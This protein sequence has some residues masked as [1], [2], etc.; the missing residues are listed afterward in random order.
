[1][2]AMKGLSESDNTFRTA[3]FVMFG[4][5]FLRVIFHC[6]FIAVL[7]NYRLKSH[8][9]NGKVD[10]S[11][12]HRQIVG[13]STA[14]LLW[15]WTDITG[16]G[17]FVIPISIA[18]DS[19]GNLYVVDDWG[20]SF[21]KYSNGSWSDVADWEAGYP[22]GVTVDGS[23][24]LYV[25]YITDADFPYG[26]VKRRVNDSWEDITGNIPFFEPAGIAVDQNGDAYV[27]SSPN[28][29]LKG[30]NG[31]WSSV[32][33][34]GYCPAAVA[35]DSSG[36]MYSIFYHAGS[37]CIGYTGVMKLSGGTWIELGEIPKTSVEKYYYNLHIDRYDNIYAVNSTNQIYKMLITPPEVR[38][39]NISPDSGEVAQGGSLQL[40]AIVDAV[41]FADESVTWSSSDGKITVD[42]T[43]KVTAAADAAP[44]D[45]TITATSV[46][47]GTKQG[48]ATIT[49]TG[50]Q[51]TTAPVISLT[52]A[53]DATQTGATLHFTSDEAGMYYY[54]VYK[55]SEPAPDAPA[56]EA[57]GTA[58]AKGTGAANAGANTISVTSGLTAA[59]AYKAYLIVKD[60]AGNV[61]D[62]AEIS[63]TTENPPNSEISPT[64][65]TF[66]KYSESA[67]YKDIPVTL[68]LKGNQLGSIA[69]GSTT[70]EVGMD[71]TVSGKTVTI[72]K[73]YLEELEVGTVTL[74]FSFNAGEPQTLTITIADTTP[75]AAPELQSATAGNAQVAL[76]W[77]PVAGSTE[78]KIFSSES[79]GI[80]AEPAAT[81]SGSVYSHTVTGLTNGTTYYFVVKAV[82]SGTDSEASNEKSAVPAAPTN[83]SA[84]AGNG[85]ATVF[86]TAPADNGGS[87]IIEYEVTASPG[88]QSVK[89]T[90]S[91]ITITGLINGTSY[92]FTVKVINEAGSGAASAASNAVIPTEPDD[93]DGVDPP[94]DND[95]GSQS[96]GSGGTPSAPAAPQT[97]P[98]NG[99]PGIPILFN[100][101]SVNAGTAVESTRND[102]TVTTIVID[103]EKLNDMLVGE[104]ELAV[105]TIPVVSTADVIVAELN[106]QQV[107]NMEDKQSV[108]EI[109]SDRATY[110][111]PA[112][113]VN[114]SAISQQ[115]GESVSLQDIKIQI[116]I[117]APTTDMLSII[118]NAAEQGSFALVVPPVEFS[119]KAVYGDT[120]LEATHFTAYVERTIV[121]PD[122]VDPAK[123]TTAIVVEPDGTVR[124]V[125]TQ[126]KVIDG[127]YHAVINSLTNSVYSVIWH[128][129][130]FSDAASHWAKDA[131]NDMGS[132]LVISGTEDGL[133]T[134]DR[135]ITRAEFA[136]IIVRGLGLKTEGDSPVFADVQSTDWY[137]SIIAT[138]HAYGLI[139]GY[140]DGT[141]RLNEKMTRE[142]AMTIIARAMKLTGL[143]EQL[144]D[145]SAD[146][147]LQSFR[148]ASAVSAWALNGAA[149]TVQAGIISGK[150]AN[151]LDPKANMTRAEVAAVIQRLL[152]ISGL[153]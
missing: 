52:S 100:G 51:D 34:A 3:P 80:Y 132:R 147:T 120:T 145:Q 24:N 31:E 115:L 15:S 11:M 48:T 117:A 86:F 55:A 149:D 38:G 126:I 99:D 74:T 113:Q 87:A 73:E 61:S 139:S 17:Q 131:I 83:V 121:I 127:K 153:I 2:D 141:F 18:V 114:I 20:N 32:P 13:R 50:A 76:T 94:N 112:E 7:Y 63:F 21:K 75:L 150:S 123:I 16:S 106:G 97:A 138:A 142:Q 71:Y 92:T 151:T 37:G 119:V 77:S 148:D 82:K 135:D 56:I 85:Q 103:S 53:S 90:V 45:Y 9:R 62:V 133:F 89:G 109:Q 59:T 19:E 68:T 30:S 28:Q 66:D 110:T 93:D 36:E 128:P 84:V 95:S 29:I 78:Y 81:V 107:K 124:H 125:P 111:L 96:G 65:A 79:S 70:L 49:V 44:G 140:E 10:W 26:G 47:D 57:Q 14:A 33:L 108:L 41:G 22:A 72:R 69:N 35:V 43:G 130:E 54:V 4:Q 64:T 104:S 5:L 39:V 101:K 40:T 136:A 42:E 60:E 91:P 23:D 116:E 46:F 122:G 12:K 98:E 144:P 134:P 105:I 118:E 143:K 27:V 129:Q 67:S 102:Q 152:K 6:A 25:T 137:S 58:A 146:I 8:S 1:M 88:G